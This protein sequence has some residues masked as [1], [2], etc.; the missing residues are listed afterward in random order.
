MKKQRTI[1]FI[2]LVLL[3]ALSVIAISA[4]S[5]PNAPVVDNTTNNVDGSDTINDAETNLVTNGT[6]A[7]A[8][9]E[10]GSKYVK[11]DTVKGWTAKTGS[12]IYTSDDDKPTANTTFGLVQG[13]VDLK[14]WKDS[15]GINKT[16]YGS[17]TAPDNI[18][19]YSTANVDTNTNQ[20]EEYDDSN[21]L[22]IA[23]DMSGDEIFN[24]SSYY[25]S[26]TTFATE[27][28][29]SYVLSI[30]VLT[31]LL[32]GNKLD[33]EGDGWNTED[34]GK[35]AYIVVTD[36]NNSYALN[37][38]EAINT[39]GEWKTI[40]I[41][42]EANEES[43]MNLG[44][45]LW[46]GHGTAYVQTGTV[47]ERL[48]KGVCLFDN[49]I[50]KETTATKYAEADAAIRTK[51]AA[52]DT[53]ANTAYYNDGTSHVLSLKDFGT[54]EKYALYAYASKSQTS[55]SYD[56]YY[57]ARIGN[58][59]AYTLMKGVEN[60]SDYSS[61]EL[62]YYS[63]SSY[64]PYGIFDYSKV[65]SWTTNNKLEDE[66][67][68]KNKTDWAGFPTEDFY[69]ATG[70]FDNNA[71]K[72]AFSGVNLL[73]TK[74]LLIYNS[75]PS[76]V[77]Y[78]ANE[79]VTIE[80]GKYYTLTIYT[81]LYQTLLLDGTS[82]NVSVDDVNKNM[83]KIKTFNNASRVITATS[84]MTDVTFDGQNDIAE[85][86]VTG[87]AAYAQAYRE[88]VLETTTID[89]AIRDKWTALGDGITS[90]PAELEYYYAVETTTTSGVKYYKLALSTLSL[91][92]YTEG[93]WDSIEYNL[94]GNTLGDREMGMQLWLGEGLKDA[95]TLVM[96]GAIFTDITIVESENPVA[97]KSY[98]KLSSFDAGV[99]Y[100]IYGL[101]SGALVSDFGLDTQ[102]LV[103]SY[104]TN[105]MTIGDKSYVIYNGAAY[106]INNSTTVGKYDES[107]T[108]VVYKDHEDV[109][110]TYYIDTTTGKVYSNK[111]KTLSSEVANVHYFDTYKLLEDK[112]IVGGTDYYYYYYF[113]SD[114]VYKTTAI[115]SSNFNKTGNTITLN[116]NQ[117]TIA[118]MTEDY[119]EAT[120]MHFDFK[121]ADGLYNSGTVHAY[122]VTSE[123]TKEKWE[124]NATL[125][126]YSYPYLNEDVK[127]A[128][129]A[130]DYT[131]F[132]TIVVTHQSASASILTLG[133]STDYYAAAK[134]YPNKYYRYSI[135]VKTGE[136]NIGTAT[137]QLIA[138][139]TASDKKT[140]TSLKSVTSI[141]TKGEWV[142]YV[143]YVSGA[144][145]ENRDFNA[146]TAQLLFGS[147]DA[148]SPDTHAKGV[149]YMTA[150]TFIEVNYSEYSSKNTGENVSSYSYSSS[151][152]TS[153]T[154][155]NGRFTS[156]DYDKT[157]DANTDY[158]INAYDENGK[159]IG[160]GTPSGGW[161]AV[162]ASYDKMTTPT[163]KLDTVTSEDPYAVAEIDE[164]NVSLDLSSNKD[165][166][167]W[168]TVPNAIAYAL[169]R[170]TRKTETIGELPT[171]SIIK[172]N[173]E[174]KVDGN[175]VTVYV[176]NP[177]GTAYTDYTLAKDKDSPI[178]STAA[179]DSVQGIDTV[180]FT[181]DDS[182]K[183]YKSVKLY[184][185]TAEWDT[186]SVYVC[187]SA[188][189]TTSTLTNTT[190]IK[191]KYRYTAITEKYEEKLAAPTTEAD[192]SGTKVSWTANTSNTAK[193]LRYVIEVYTATDLDT[194]AATFEVPNNVAEPH[195]VNYHTVERAYDSTE[196]Y[197]VKAVWFVPDVKRAETKEFNLTWTTQL[198]QNVV[199]GTPDA[200]YKNYY[201][202]EVYFVP[203]GEASKD[204][205]FVGFATVDANSAPS[206]SAGITTHTYKYTYKITNLVKGTYYVR[207]VVDSSLY[208]TVV[209]ATKD[210][211]LTYGQ[212]YSPSGFATVYVDPDQYISESKYWVNWSS[213]T[214]AKYEKKENKTT[215]AA[216]SGYSISF[217]D[218]TTVA[219]VKA[220][221]E[222]KSTITYAGIISA[223][224]AEDKV[225]LNSSRKAEFEQTLQEV[226][227]TEGLKYNA[228][229]IYQRSQAEKDAG[230]WSFGYSD[231]AT[232]FYTINKKYDNLLMIAS[233][234][235]TVKGYTSSSSTTLTA[236]SY[237]VLSFW[238]KTACGAK[239]SIIIDNQSNIYNAVDNFDGFRSI[240]TNNEWIQYRLLIK[241][242][243]NDAQ[244][245]VGLYLGE[246]NDDNKDA[247][248]RSSGIVFFDDI[249]FIK[250]ADKDAYDKYFTAKEGK[251]IKSYSTSKTH[252]N[253]YDTVEAS[254][255]YSNG[256]VYETLDYVTDSFD[257][258]KD[259]AKAV[260]GNTPKDYTQA[261]D[262]GDD[263]IV[264]DNEA[265]AYGVYNAD[266]IVSTTDYAS[267]I[268]SGNSYDDDDVRAQ[269]WYTIN[270]VSDLSGFVKGFGSNSLVLANFMK[271]AQYMKSSSK[272]LEA[273][274]YYKITFYAKAML[275][276][277]TYAEFRLYNGTD[278]KTSKYQSVKIYGINTTGGN[279]NGM[280]EYTL[281]TQNATDSSVSAIYSFHLGT[282]AVTEKDDD[283]E[284]V[285]KTPSNLLMGILVI[286]NVT[287][288]KIDETAYD[289][290]VGTAEETGTLKAAEATN[291][292]AYLL[293]REGYYEILPTTSED[294]TEEEEGATDEEEDGSSIGAETWLILS[295]AIIG[296]LILIVVVIFMVKQFK[297][298]YVKVKVVGENKVDAE[299]KSEV[300]IK[301][302]KQ[303]ASS[304]YVKDRKDF[305][306]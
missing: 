212:K 156:V 68:M 233:D 216:P 119:K 41:Y 161:T 211:T 234:V 304:A 69:D 66:Y 115:S 2:I 8:Y 218:F 128:D 248:V 12:A 138:W 192:G 22:M 146:L 194:P 256:F 154:V 19:D 46:M 169:Y 135:L 108:K 175:V 152:Y 87:Y 77:G 197:V 132:S 302:Q 266:N 123:I 217:T 32:N 292:D 5:D 63:S 174:I 263:N 80:Q 97:G 23:S 299:K 167:S 208:N 34:Y 164:A 295:S 258:H 226:F 225:F 245:K 267:F 31:L 111:Q 183:S 273:N 272:T 40:N 153:E 203:D 254:T 4:C 265:R 54:I 10:S 96:G 246:P 290:A 260:I 13:V 221:G 73:D 61:D 205:Y 193:F 209:D 117:Y 70:E 229:S 214:F 56:Y 190:P 133:D 170:R 176:P 271:N 53:D 276:A 62:P 85:Y 250:L 91:P 297:K 253:A 293:G 29:K 206:T 303:A 279:V 158:D 196:K 198:K 165:T 210:A 240:S 18:Y 136:N 237:Y 49:V 57:T 284:T 204:K 15:N 145:V 171:T 143:F 182:F 48:T 202:Y 39:Y 255:I 189:L 81:Y 220:S 38:V 93:G 140:A 298:K 105:T 114:K 151:L 88:K 6:F 47:N 131:K 191:Y 252:I 166:V 137:L 16:L 178:F 222:Q 89:Q 37:T 144:Y 106:E 98:K 180:V 1:Y 28:G 104:R 223:D 147:G 199:N 44:I 72:T 84:K 126:G 9:N 305:E 235:D 27:K 26:S 50:M 107:L 188:T 103:G 116:G 25:Y 195:T 75:K 301:Q 125:K 241:V 264:N 33:Q 134:V 186:E 228:E 162:E 129:T 296:L 275:K 30:D 181:V 184:Y 59:S 306:D 291:K 45:Q 94:A 90:L 120:D 7:S 92:Y 280:Y 109:E 213:A 282:G 285:I 179:H 239:A 281:Y 274:S 294:P 257:I 242:G 163:V 236:S 121:A 36:S 43:D 172:N 24:S 86:E 300:A 155:T 139:N 76:G 173:I 14:K 287:L 177:T 112:L 200:N 11:K 74:G 130:D 52:G 127:S 251:E 262:T 65:Y 259:D 224:F 100:D 243:F 122:I 58:P 79:M 231:P 277:D 232:K 118:T 64:L 102:K 113:N 286:D 278:I 35:G 168:S 141:D 219:P 101:T 247:V 227:P 230:I 67:A 270:T 110:Q 71:F 82:S 142:E 288:E 60:Y 215:D 261:M 244:I 148:Y 201:Q 51:V 3:L 268:K 160:I 249:N 150:P 124:S 17:D 238:V 157:V 20:P 289:D 42:I 159:L 187:T 149:V 283:G 55:T 269:D 99:N 185:D 207:A 95:D 78:K 83:E 21:V